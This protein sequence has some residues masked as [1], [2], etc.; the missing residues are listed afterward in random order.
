M[1]ETQRDLDR[2]QLKVAESL[3][4]LT[5]TEA[6]FCLL[7]ALAFCMYRSAGD[8][9]ELDDRGRTAEERRETL[10]GVVVEQIRQQWREVDAKRA[11]QGIPTIKHH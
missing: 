3:D 4:G 8:T 7:N 1:P 9:G 6:A 11:I 5:Y 10:L 2:M